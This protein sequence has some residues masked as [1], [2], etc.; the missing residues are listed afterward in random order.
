MASP[1]AVLGQWPH[2]CEEMRG[3]GTY[4]QIDFW[5]DYDLPKL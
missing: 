4:V 5:L 1:A 3:K 2:P